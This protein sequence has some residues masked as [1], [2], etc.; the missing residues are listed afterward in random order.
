MQVFQYAVTLLEAGWGPGLNRSWQGD[1][2][3]GY[4][5]QS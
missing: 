2:P 3:G 4:F 1:R 5:A